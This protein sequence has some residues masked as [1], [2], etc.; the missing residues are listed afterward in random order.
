MNSLTT[1][2]ARWV[3]RNSPVGLISHIPSDWA[4]VAIPFLQLLALP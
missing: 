3:V 4:L 2:I 1:F